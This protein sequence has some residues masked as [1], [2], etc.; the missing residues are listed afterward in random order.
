MK[1]KQLICIGDIYAVHHGQYAGEL[2]IYI[3]TCNGSHCFLATPT[4]EN[5]EVPIESFDL[6]RNS[7]IIKFVEKAPK[8]VVKISEAQYKNN[9][10]SNN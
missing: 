5:R 6:G 3:K 10:N 1:V 2:L 8:Y 9:E 7:D 4:M